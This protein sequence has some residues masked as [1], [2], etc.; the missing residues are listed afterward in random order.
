MINIK[1][2]L[3][4]VGGVMC[5]L[6]SVLPNQKVSAVSFECLNVGMEGSFKLI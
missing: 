5:T 6:Y 4:G 3:F 1:P 2:G